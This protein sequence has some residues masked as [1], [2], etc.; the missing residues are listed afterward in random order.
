MDKN[1]KWYLFMRINK[2][3]DN[4]EENDMQGFYVKSR[5]ELF[6]KIKELVPKE[7][8]IGIGDS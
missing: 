7:S 6:E 4:L 3:L 1:S 8:V 5:E 2:L